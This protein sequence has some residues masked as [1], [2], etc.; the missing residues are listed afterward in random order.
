M[1][2]TP[3]PREVAKRL[4]DAEETLRRAVRACEELQ[5]SSQQLA[6]A[7]QNLSDLTQAT[8]DLLKASA[9]VARD[10]LIAV[11]AVRALDPATLSARF[12]EAV[13]AV[14][15]QGRNV[16]RAI[17]LSAGLVA[18]LLLAALVLLRK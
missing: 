18:L 1:S 17:W 2:T 13:E 10:A 6:E 16:V 8:R 15:T 11:Q 4:L 7:R 5:Q 9:T 3:E 12:D 14:K